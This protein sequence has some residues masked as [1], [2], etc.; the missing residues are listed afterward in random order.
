MGA[1]GPP[2]SALLPQPP[3][4]SCPAGRTH[5]PSWHLAQHLSI[6]VFSP[7]WK[8]L[9]SASW[10]PPGLGL[11]PRGLVGPR[12]QSP[13]PLRPCRRCLRNQKQVRGCGWTTP[14]LLALLST[15][16]RP[17]EVP[18]LAARPLPGGAPGA[19]ELPAPACVGHRARAQAAQQDLGGQRTGRAPHRRVLG[20][21][22][23]LSSQK[24][25]NGRFGRGW[26]LSPQRPPDPLLGEASSMQP[27]AT[28]PPGARAQPPGLGL[29]AGSEVPPAPRAEDIPGRSGTDRQSPSNRQSPEVRSATRL[30]VGP[31]GTAALADEGL[32]GAPATGCRPAP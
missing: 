28:R 4:E 30:P 12:T 11:L 13:R 31:Q 32:Q 22:R 29:A 8:L 27:A 10:R 20:A 9:G 24:A 19:V 1:P 25:A 5:A 15:S 26:Q 17:Q 14:H 7:F 16:P 2:D 18:G 21:G 23:L 6:V 3:P